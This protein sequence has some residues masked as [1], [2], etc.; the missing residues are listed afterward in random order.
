MESKFNKFVRSYTGIALALAWPDTYCKQAGAWYDGL[1]NSLGIAKD[2][3]YKVGHAAL[4]LIDKSE[5]SCYYY[6]FGRYHTPF[7]HGRVRSS[8]TDHDLLIPVK[9]QFKERGRLANLEEIMVFLANNVAC[10]GTGAVHAGYCELNFELAKA[11]AVELQLRSPILYGPFIWNGTNCS[12][13]VR[14]VLLAGRP[15]LHRK[16]R[17]LFSDTISPT[18]MANVRAIRN[19][20]SWVNETDLTNAH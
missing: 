17:L 19:L 10:H 6:D 14:S 3:Y 7:G 15:S 12:R 2:N 11:T 5:G 13:F 1:M 16:L 9:A 18:P 4:V 8:D 20:G